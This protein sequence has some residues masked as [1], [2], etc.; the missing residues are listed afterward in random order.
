MV[1]RAMATTDKELTPADVTLEVDGT[2]FSCVRSALAIESPYF[3]AMFSNNF[4]ERNKTVIE[5]QGL[6]AATMKFILQWLDDSTAIFKLQCVEVLAV[7][8]AAAMLQFQRL[9]QMCE[10]V[11]VQRWLSPESCLM[12]AATADRLSLAKLYNKASALALWQ[13]CEVRNTQ[14]FLDLPLSRLEQYLKQDALSLGSS[15]DEFQVFE[16]ICW[17]LEHK[18]VERKSDTLKALSCVRMNF[19]SVSDIQTMFNYACIEN[20][21]DAQDLLRCIL[22]IKEERQF[23]ILHQSPEQDMEPFKSLVGEK[24]ISCSSKAPP[25]V[26]SIDKA[27]IKHK[28][29]VLPEAEPVKVCVMDTAS[30]QI[31]SE[32]EKLIE[33]F[34]EA[35]VK[36]SRDILA[37]PSRQVAT[38]P[39]VIGH[40]KVE[41]NSGPDEENSSPSH[42]HAKKNK[43]EKARNMLPYV[44]YWNPNR[45]EKLLPLMPLDKLDQGPTEPIG[46]AVLSKGQE[47]YVVGGEYLIGYGDWNRSVLKYNA[48]SESWTFETSLAVPR[49]HHSVVCI[50]DDMYVVGGSGKF[51]VILDSVDR[52]NFTSRTWYKCAPLPSALYSAAACVH[53]NLVYVISCR[54]FCYNPKTDNWVT[55]ND[56]QLPSGTSYNTAL[57]HGNFIYLTGLYSEDLVRFDPEKDKCV[58][59]VG[60][61]QYTAGNVCLVG[62]KIYSFPEHNECPCVEVYNIRKNTFEVLFTGSPSSARISF[63]KLA[64]HCFPLVLYET[65]WRGP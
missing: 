18:M 53:N 31:E 13:F 39:C 21:E 44:F 49:R 24:T 34:S 29:E 55:L 62:D 10:D 50:D 12:T 63:K 4:A 5:I 8:Q 42:D 26:D 17:W 61:F 35:T 57:T 41:N 47:L 15:E 58:K 23:A 33:E 56:V 6:D 11:M 32:A 59:L 51:R 45:S 3:E 27:S 40:Y 25:A 36:M 54:V 48:W 1:N 60:R 14:E 22:C 46:Y 2:L 43:K 7:L 16:A 19:I 9:Q 28:L 37:Q 52:Y 20:R 64:R 65:L 38:V 30:V